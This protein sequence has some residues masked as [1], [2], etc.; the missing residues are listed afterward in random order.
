M[1]VGTWHKVQ[2]TMFTSV[3]NRAHMTI[4]Q[5]PNLQDYLDSWR[6]LSTCLHMVDNNNR[7]RNEQH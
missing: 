4:K 1:E 5:T 3:S 2:R 7:H 6:I